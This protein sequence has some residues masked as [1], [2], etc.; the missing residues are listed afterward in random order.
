M[1]SILLADDHPLTLEGTATFLERLKYEIVHRAT[2]GT[3][4]LAY[5]EKYAPDLAILDIEM[6]GLDGLEVLQILHKTKLKTQ[7]ILLTMHNN[8]GIVKKAMELGCQGF[9]LKNYALEELPKCIESVRSGKPFISS[10][11]ENFNQSS[12]LDLNPNVLN[13][14]EK[15]ILELIGKRFTSKQIAEHLYISEKTVEAYRSSIIKKLNLPAEK[16]ILLHIAA[17]YYP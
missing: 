14:K 15:K 7:V 13:L 10:N 1:L 17:Q 5:I 6:P 9:V 3:A 2:N 11:L 4:A 16:N 12:T 8:S